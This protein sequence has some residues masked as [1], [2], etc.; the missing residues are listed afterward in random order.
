MKQSSTASAGN[1]RPPF[2][3]AFYLSLLATTLF[4]MGLTLTIPI[5][6]LFVTDE[7]G[8]AEHWVG[9]A[10]FFVTLAAVGTRIPAGA[11]SDRHGR[12]K[13]MLIGGTLGVAAAM[14]YIITQNLVTLLCARMITGTSIALF[15][16]T[17]KALA[18]DLSP[19]ARR[20]EA[21]GLNNAAFSVASV[22]SPIIGEGLK[23][24]TG[25]R[26]V[27]AL[28]AV[29]MSGAL[30]ATYH[31][32]RSAPERNTPFNASADVKDTLRQR[33]MWAA[34]L[35]MLSM[36][37]ILAVLY[38]FYPLLAERKGLFSDA[39]GLLSPIAIGLGLSIWSVIDTVVEPVSGRLSDRI[40]RQPI[41]IPGLVTT[42]LGLF[43]LGRAHNT[44][45]TLSAIALLA[46]GW[47]M[48]RGSA[49]A[50]AQDALP[51]VL[52]GMGAAVLYTS[53]DFAVGSS[54]QFLGGL[55]NG[56]DFS[57]FFPAALTSVLL[58]GV[59]GLALTTRLIPHDQREAVPAP[60][61]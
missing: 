45:S 24:A 5:M 10:T 26:A 40:G 52:R 61:D 28:S 42:A 48:A 58:F 31:L 33:G 2:P 17:G 56:S 25:F 34:I 55:V 50:V 16:T 38:T 15:T 18:A 36:G 41:V 29:L 39:P 3:R 27:F 13:I 20:G 7:I 19:A 46:A 60:G 54:A 43:I 47:G 6:S 44:A 37:T 51:P 35:I 57:G 21:M 22:I 53:F 1:G 4:S 11:F 8:L 49:D 59:A 32:P 23:N 9:T 14:M 30:V 12:R